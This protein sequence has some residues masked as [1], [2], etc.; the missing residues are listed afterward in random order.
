MRGENQK[1]WAAWRASRRARRLSDDELRAIYDEQYA[2]QYDPHAVPRMERLLPYI[3]LSGSETVAD[4]GCGNG[5][6]LEVISPKV[7]E[8][9]GVDFSEAFVRAAEQRRDARGIRNGSF[10]CTDMVAFCSENPGRF[11][12]GFALDFSEH[13]YDDQFLRIF[14]AIH[15]ALKPGAALYL[16][17]PNREYFIELMRDRHILQPIEGHV[18]VRDARRNCELL[19]QCGFEDIE[20]HHLAH[21]LQAASAF[22]ALGALPLIGRFF[23]ARLFLRCRKGA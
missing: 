2:G 12:A 7:R 3:Q 22:H 5:V 20:V 17:T 1:G 16:H 21:Y 11:D 18:A 19:A 4:F 23:R 6:L 9:V 15:T 13:I 8:Y 10:H 14:Q